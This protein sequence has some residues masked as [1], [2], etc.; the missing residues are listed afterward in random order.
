M[1]SVVKY[2]W[3]QAFLKIIFLV[4]IANIVWQLYL[5]IALQDNK[6]PIILDQIPNVTARSANIRTN[7][8]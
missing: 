7:T 2:G 4:L 5:S 8:M 6:S 1:F 3:L